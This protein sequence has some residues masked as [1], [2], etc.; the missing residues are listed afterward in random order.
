MTQVMARPLLRRIPALLLA[1]SLAAGTSGCIMSPRTAGNLASVAT[2]ALWTAAIVGEVALLTY[3]DTHYHFD[4][5]GHYRRWH[6]GHWVYFY[7]GHW[8][9]YDD[10]VSSWY[11][12]D[13]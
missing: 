5:C 3:H 8:E 6:G 9:Y 7:G 2:A 12:Y 4:G 10:G 13:E 11:Y 1:L